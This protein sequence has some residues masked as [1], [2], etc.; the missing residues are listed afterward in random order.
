MPSE[1]HLEPELRVIWRVATNKKMP[2]PFFRRGRHTSVP[3]KRRYRFLHCKPDAT[4]Y[5][6]SH[7]GIE[8]LNYTIFNV[9]G[10]L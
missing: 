10:G 2:V 3:E 6:A 1:H 5:D 8:I 9:L 7:S 4:I